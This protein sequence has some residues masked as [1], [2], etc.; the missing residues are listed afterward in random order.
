MMAG[1]FKH[2]VEL[3]VLAVLVI[4]GGWNIEALAYL[5]AMVLLAVA[6]ATML[7][8]LLQAAADPWNHHGHASLHAC[9]PW[10][11]TALAVLT[12]A[13][14][15]L[16]IIMEFAPPIALVIY[17]LFLGYYV[18]P[19]V[20]EYLHQHATHTAHLQTGLDPSPHLP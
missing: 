10:L 2:K 1:N 19:P 12:V 15:P 5:V 17:A 14:P 7:D 3:A 16:L 20:Q 4:A 9:N 11:V 13:V 8:V 18:N 6:S